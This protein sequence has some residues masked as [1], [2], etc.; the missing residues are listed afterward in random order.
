MS[1]PERLVLLA[2]LAG[3]LLLLVRSE[4][5]AT[6]VGAVAGGGLGVALSGRLRRLGQRVDA[7]IGPDDAPPPTGLRLHRPLLR[8]ALLGAVL[9][10][11]GASTLVLPFVGDELAGALAGAVTAVPL[12]LTAAGLRR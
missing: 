6:V 11:V 4:T 8:L 3:L 1:R 5:T 7:R 9:V 10:V 12:V 2:L